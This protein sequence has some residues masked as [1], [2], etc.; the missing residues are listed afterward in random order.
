MKITDFLKIPDIFTFNRFLIFEPHPDDAD[1]FIGGIIKKLTNMKKEVILITVT[2]GSK[3]TYDPFE[4]E[5]SIKE[6]RKEERLNSSFI[7]GVKDTIF[8]EY[9]DYDLPDK[10]NL[11]E[12][13]IKLIREFKPDCVFTVDPFLSYEVHPDHKLVG[14][15]VSE[16]FFFAPMPLIYKEYPPYFVKS[17][18]YYITQY[19]NS[20][21]DITETYNFKIEAIKKHK[22]QFNEEDLIKMELYLNYK[23]GE[24][25]K[26]IGVNFAEAVKILTPLHIHTNVDTINL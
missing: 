16:A 5:N 23:N 25:G 14:E 8:L 22:S 18:V 21:I 13:F 20:F 17:I 11:V 3:G 6:K 19:P 4:N 7:L 26:K 15:S 1:I 9:R 2:D 12:K 24:Y 10:K